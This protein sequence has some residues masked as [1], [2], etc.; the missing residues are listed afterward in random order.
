MGTYKQQII[1]A[2]KGRGGRRRG[3]KET[4]WGSTETNENKKSENK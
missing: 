3:I 2:R 4:I 1:I